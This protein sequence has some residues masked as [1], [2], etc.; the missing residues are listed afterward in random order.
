MKIKLSEHLCE[1]EKCLKVGKHSK[2]RLAPKKHAKGV[3]YELE[4]DSEK[5]VCYY[6]L[7]DCL[8]K[9]NK[10]QKFEL[11]DYI[12]VIYNSKNSK[13]DE[14]VYIW[15]ETKKTSDLNKCC[16][17][18]LNAYNNAVIYDK[19]IIHYA[20]IIVG[21]T[22]KSEISQDNQKRLKKIF[23]ERFDYSSQVY[24]KDKTSTLFLR[25]IN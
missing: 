15:V 3:S 7:D 25:K 19:E 13:Q 6:D 22:N 12:V 24:N 2:I 11:C 4:N 1:T 14:D 18:I 20:R 23:K 16:S 10:V 9:D 5:N 8:F 21:N 17:Q